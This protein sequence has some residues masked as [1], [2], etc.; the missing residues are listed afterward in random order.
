MPDYR[1]RAA[2]EAMTVRLDVNG[3]MA[4]AIGASGLSRAE[5][6]ACAPR[7]AET[8]ELLARRR[9]TGEIGFL[10]PHRHAGSLKRMYALA[11]ELRAQIDTLVVLGAGTGAKAILAAL[12]GGA[13]V[14]VLV[15]DGM[16]P[17]AFGALLD[18][19]D[20]TR[21]AF[22]LI[23][24]SGET[25]ETLA[26]FLIVRHRLLRA[27]GAVDYKR[28]VV[29]ATDAERGTLRQI[30]NDE[31]FLD[32]PLAAHDGAAF[33]ILAAAGLF[34]AAVA[35]ARIDE[36]LA[37]VA[38]MDGRAQ[39]EQLWENPVHL[40]AAALHLVETRKRKN[41]VV[42]LPFSDRL[43]WFGAWLAELW[44]QAL[45]RGAGEPAEHG[46]SGQMLRP[47]LALCELRAQA[48]LCLAGADDKL[49]LLFRVED[50]GRELE[51][52]AAYADLE[53]ASYLGG[54]G[55]GALLDVQ[56]RSIEMSLQRRGRLAMTIGVP[57]VN[58]FALG[59][60]VYL[61]Q[62]AALL[63]AALRGTD[64]A[65]P[66]RLDES[67]RRMYGMLGRSGWENERAEVTEWL[68][69]KRT[70]YVL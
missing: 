9:R 49:A 39:A 64:A 8:A 12:D 14:R 44:A 43:V 33:G 45:G 30:V 35:G 46:D 23:S 4:E 36:I 52:P 18:G 55:L 16:D 53:G 21:T 7:V 60:L 69:A 67:R 38:W 48:R 65:E 5:V 47:L 70:H 40:L 32:L 66:P 58:A 63:A 31:G 22:N 19:L 17:G 15:A 59:Q 13:R 1:R 50:H 62:A 37:G 6:D 27:L 29:V 11:E 54:K 24:G 68:E 2:R 26:Q 34:P 20:P 51:V 42:A 25:C 61:F 28:R 10:D 41:V 57:Q 3:V 56:Q